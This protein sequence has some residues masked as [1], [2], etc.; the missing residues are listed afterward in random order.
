MSNV[1]RKRGETLRK[2]VRNVGLVVAAGLIEHKTG[3]KVTGAAGKGFQ[4]AGSAL[5]TAG[6]NIKTFGSNVKKSF[7]ESYNPPKPKKIPKNRRLNAANVQPDKLTPKPKRL[8]AG[9]GTDRPGTIHTPSPKK[10]VRRGQGGQPK[11]SKLNVPKLTGGVMGQGKIGGRKLNAAGVNLPTTGMPKGPGTKAG[12]FKPKLT[13]DNKLMG[14]YKSIAKTKAS[15]KK[16]QTNLI[17][18]APGKAHQPGDTPGARSKARASVAGKVK[19]SR[20]RVS[21]KVTKIKKSIDTRAKQIAK[22]T[23]RTTTQVKQFNKRMSTP[24][25]KDQLNK[26]YLGSRGIKPKVKLNAAAMLNPA[27]MAIDMAGQYSKAT[28]PDAYTKGIFGGDVA[29][30][31][32]PGFIAQTSTGKKIKKRVSGLKNKVR[33][34]F[35]F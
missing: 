30:K 7:M 15:A 3:Y 6:R 1:T 17:K 22:D 23:G 25:G 29:K 9:S 21:T 33:T 24:A 31:S 13:L 20:K 10:P 2:K 8:G 28:N 19:A 35:K 34:R 12:S 18:N 11:A 14:D 26:A 16:R 4:K 5:G 27:G 32:I